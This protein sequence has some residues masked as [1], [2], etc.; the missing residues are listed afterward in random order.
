MGVESGY[1]ARA[2]VAGPP[3]KVQRRCWCTA[4][5]ARRVGIL[6]DG[7]RQDRWPLVSCSGCGV[8]ALFPQPSPSDLT[9]AYS[10]AYYGASARKFVA[11]VAAA[12][13]LFQAERARRTCAL[14]RRGGRILD[15]GCGNG[16]FLIRMRRR[17]YVVE[18]TEWTHSSAARVPEGSGLL[19]HVGDLE[20]L[21]LEPHSFDAVTLWHVLEHMRRPDVTLRAARNLLKGDGSLFLSL[22][23]VESAQAARHGLNWFHHDPPRHLFGFGPQSLSGLLHC[24]GFRAAEISTFSLEQNPFGEVQ[25][26]LN[27][28]GYPR[29]RLYSLLTGQSSCRPSTRITDLL[30]L[31]VLAAPALVRSTVESM[32]GMGAT[33]T[34]RATMIPA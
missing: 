32:R 3:S 12:V 17:G 30:R 23:N 1:D 33:M 11:P 15:V 27:A 21:R 18:G 19:V 28:R 2:D 6:Y 29:D 14:V 4:D 24:A 5:T 16:G 20:D 31:L 26:A 7:N 8:I 9:A 22:P 34:V 13:R 25:S 10:P